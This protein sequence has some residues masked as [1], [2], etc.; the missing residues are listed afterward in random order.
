MKHLFSQM[1]PQRLKNIGY[2][3]PL[4]VFAAI[5]FQFPARHLKVIG[6]TGTNG[7]TTTAQFIAKILQKSGKKIAL[8]S[9][10]NFA[11]GDRKWTNSSKF[12]TLSAWKLQKFLRDAVDSR[13]EYAIIETSSHALDQYRVWGITYEVAVITNVT[14]EHLDYHRTMDAYRRAKRRLLERANRV[15]VNLDME[16]PDEYLGVKNAPESI[17][18][19]VEK[20]E[21]DV[22]TEQLRLDSGG[23]S[24]MVQGR[25]FQIH[26]PGRYNVE[27]AL[28]SLA[29]AQ[30][31]GIDF[32]VAGQ[33]LDELSGVPG[34]M[35]SVSNTRGLHIF[36]DYAVTPDSLEKLYTLVTNM[37]SGDA[38]IV[39][40]FGSCGE[41]DRGKRP[42]MGSIVSSYADI[43]ILTNED[44]YYEDPE[45]ILDEIE[46]G[47]SGK[48]KGKNYWRISDR[49]EAIAQALK[50]A[51]S[52][53]WVI[54]TGKGAEE[55]LAIGDARFPWN[56][57]AVIEEELA[58][59]S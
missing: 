36:I 25:E 55:T 39:S 53:D 30:M 17:S 14:R 28:A 18:Y 15:V 29:V 48:E 56:E 19:S 41:R 10:I 31:F 22:H 45:Q 54:V 4:A 16:N 11:I 47:I 5:Y 3:F 21:A 50:V 6:I 35:E 33:A 9:T 1:I 57:R 34:R 26:L 44:P 8:A 32:S 12:T 58:K 42:I 37:R 20:C 49:R 7:K 40:V 2:H 24:F 51:R 46:R 43:L 52:G 59:I 38:R 13:C 23:A 27:N